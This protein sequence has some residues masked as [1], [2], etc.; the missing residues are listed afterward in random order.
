M[1]KFVGC[2]IKTTSGRRQ[3]WKSFRKPSPWDLILKPK[4]TQFP[5][6]MQGRILT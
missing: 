1:P 6:V 2:V 4:Q 5:Y 3:L